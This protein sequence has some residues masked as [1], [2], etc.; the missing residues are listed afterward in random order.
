TVVPVAR[1]TLAG[2]DAAAVT[3]GIRPENLELAT[4]GLPLEVDVVEELGADA[5]VYG[6]AD[7]SGA[8]VDGQTIVARVDWRNPPSKGEHIFLA[9]TDP[10]AI[11]LFAT[12]S[13]RRL[14]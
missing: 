4:T 8:G 7:V 9:P 12:D 10:T 3:L 14:D 11:H 13:G 5:Y 6:R 2:A 1:D